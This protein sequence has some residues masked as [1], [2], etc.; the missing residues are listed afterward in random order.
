MALTKAQVKEILSEAGADGEK[1]ADAVQKILDGHVATIVALKE[2][3]DS[4]KA[5]I[6]QNKADLAEYEK[7]KKN[8]GDIEA[9]QKEYD[10]YKAKVEADKTWTKKESAY[11]STLK[12]AGISE[13]RI[14]TIVK[15][16]REEIEGIEFDEED[17]VKDE[18]AIIERNKT[19]WSD[20]VENIQKEGVKTPTP[21]SN[22]GSKTTMTREQIRAIPDAQARQKAMIENAS[23]FGLPE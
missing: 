13:K 18:E 11:R 14:D 8:S 21:P 23:L 5:E 4:L 1:I 10:D 7:L 20:F 2:E 12:K 22:G 19:N 17:N 9:L 15:C 3:R 6:E 16:S